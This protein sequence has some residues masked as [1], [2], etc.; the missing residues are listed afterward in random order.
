MYEVID[1]NIHMLR[2]VAFKHV[3]VKK[4]CR[5]AQML[6]YLCLPTVEFRSSWNWRV[7]GKIKTP[8]IAFDPLVFCGSWTLSL[9]ETS[10]WWLNISRET[11]VESE[12][13]LWLDWFGKFAR[14]ALSKNLC[15]VIFVGNPETPFAG[16]VWFCLHS[17][18]LKTRLQ[19]CWRLTSRE[20]V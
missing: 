10:D 7:D 15:I 19:K 11:S 8:P 3:M 13:S 17:G 20:Y 1:E 2:S 12:T 16:T 9:L 14:F 18:H 4:Y 5:N 6:I